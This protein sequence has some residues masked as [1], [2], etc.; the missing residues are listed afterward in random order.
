MSLGR[1][2]VTAYAAMGLLTLGLGGSAVISVGRLGGLLETAINRDAYKLD[3]LVDIST[4]LAKM[5]ASYRGV[6]AYS[7]AGDAALV[8]ASKREFE[9]SASELRERMASLRVDIST[10]RGLAAW[11]SLDRAIPEYIGGYQTAAQRSASGDNASA[12]E[13]AKVSA[14]QGVKMQADVAAMVAAQRAL[15]AEASTHAKSTTAAAYWTAILLIALAACV[16]AGVIVYVLSVSRTLR[17][18]TSQVAASSHEISNASD[19]VA[20]SSQMLAQG[21]SEQAASLEETSASTEEITSMTQSNRANSLSAAKAMDEVEAHVAKCNE[22][23]EQ[24]AASMKGITA[25][26]EK[27]SGILKMIDEIAFQTNILALNAAVEAARAGDA[28]RGFAIVADEV[29]TLAQRVAQA[30]KDTAAL[31][32]ESMQRSRGGG[33]KLNEMT[34]VIQGITGSAYHVRT[35]VD[36]VKAGT[37]EQARGIEQIAAAISQ[38]NQVTQSTAA[39]AEEGA[40]AAAEL[41][42]QSGELDHITKTL[43]SLVGMG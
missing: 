38:M 14:P 21:A 9:A 39:S 32:E 24:M 17:R 22:T 4:D 36:T 40:A 30:A 34:A 42:G 2:L 3:L 19:Q 18:V 27:I 33:A 37:A 26:S 8:D 29:R 12:L 13:Q 16:G 20:Q 6:L 43:S 25:S 1:K 23:L 10:E 7:Q 5:R 28:G 15:L 11:S 31:I 41:N 35:L